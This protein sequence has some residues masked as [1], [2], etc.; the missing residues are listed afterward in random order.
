VGSG[1]LS[2]KTPY[3]FDWFDWFCFRY[4]PGWL[5]LFNRHWQHYK[6]DPEG[7]SWLEYPLFLLPGGFYLAALLR[8]LRVL[9]QRWLGLSPVLSNSAQPDPVYQQAFRREILTPIVHR[10]FRAEL[11]D[12]D[13][14]PASGPL[15]IAMNHTGMCF[16]WDFLALAFLLAERRNWFLQPLAH[17]M[18][19]DHPWLHWWLPQG[20]SQVLGGIRAERELF[21]AAIAEKAILLYAPEGL[22]GVTKGWPQRHRLAAFDPSFVRL[23]VRYQVP[24]LPVVCA[25]SEYLHPYAFNIRWLAR[26]FHT[27]MFPISPLSVAFLLFPSMG[28]WVMRTKLRYRLQPIQ[29]PWLQA[30]E[31]DL[32]SYRS[33]H[34]QAE[35]LR[36]SMQEALDKVVRSASFPVR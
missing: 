26:W 12:D 14:L 9:V 27:P 28:V 19:F 5:I 21:E 31:G 22:R 6:A 18:F 2:A 35:V 3:R 25:G 8:W 17:S 15:I 24:I 16:P 33:T 23:S 34:Q 36:G 20:W 7:W 30:S 1:C 13:Y 29:Y 10:H 4:P 11:E 32:A